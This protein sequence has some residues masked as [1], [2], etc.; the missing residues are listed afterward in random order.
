MKCYFKLLSILIL[1]PFF[2]SAQSHFKPGYIVRLNG[3]TIHGYIDYRGWDL[4]PDHIKFRPITGN[5]VEKLTV[6][7]VDF[8]SIDKITS[9]KSYQVKISMDNTNEAHMINARDT[10]FKIEKVFLKI[11]QKGKNLALYSYSDAIKT[12]LYIGDQPV[13]EPVELVYRLYYNPD[14]VVSGVHGKTV[15]ENTYMVQL[16]KLALKYD[17]FSLSLQKDIEDSDYREYHVNQIVKK[18]NK[19]AK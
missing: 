13:Y 8:F 4:N 11:L 3:D 16:Y 12:R 7:D 17:I 5:S 6:N 18:M 14:A 2:S 9:Y 15:N 10:S 1:L 19:S